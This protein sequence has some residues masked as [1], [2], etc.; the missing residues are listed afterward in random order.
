MDEEKLE[1]Y[2]T[3]LKAET[4]RIR[5][6]DPE[7]AAHLDEIVR[8]IGSSL[9]SGTHDNTSEPELSEKIQGGIERFETDH[10]AA[11]EI[12]N[13]IATFFSNIGI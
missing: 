5:N 2:L 13:R 9:D 4:D 3:E 1:K 11:T 8:N 7:S 12:L 6:I 10:P